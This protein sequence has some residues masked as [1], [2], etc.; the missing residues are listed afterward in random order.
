[1]AQR[2]PKDY[3]GD[4]LLVTRRKDGVAVVTLNRP[5]VRNA[6][7][8]VSIALLHKAFQEF[9]ADK[10]IR[11]VVLRGEGKDF[12]AG[13]DIQ[14]MRKAADYSMAQNKA[15]AKK[16]EAMIRAIDECPVPVLAR[17]Q[18]NCFGGSLGLIAAADIV[19]AAKNTVLCFSETRIGILPAVVATWVI[20]KIGTS[21]ARRY[22]LTA[23]RFDAVHAQR[24]GLVHQV[25][26]PE[27]LDDE[28]NSFLEDILHNGPQSLRAAKRLI[29]NIQFA[30]TLDGR[31]AIAAEALAEARASKEGKEGLS[32][33]LE[34]RRPAWVPE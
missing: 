28:I 22:F 34:K 24:I 31:V 26:E 9:A 23:E 33:F 27:D 12:C 21:Q 17:I 3:S 14:W 6:F 19:V 13:A 11:A 20:P 10:K 25:V 7:D 32:A 4:R 18:G 29:R 2:K 1:M 30:S 16:L 5:E 15:D 8:D